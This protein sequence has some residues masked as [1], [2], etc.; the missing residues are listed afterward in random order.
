MSYPPVLKSGIGKRTKVELLRRARA[1]LARPKGW[2]KGWERLN[3][4]YEYPAYCLGSACQVAAQEMDLFRPGQE[5]NYST[6]VAD[7]ISLLKLVRERGYGS[8]VSFN[9]SRDTRKKDVL[10]VI[11]ERI[12][13]LEGE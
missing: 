10:A 2:D 8:V 13:Q 7:Q 6:D 5:T 3:D 9:D 4:G 12:A 1:L 11:D